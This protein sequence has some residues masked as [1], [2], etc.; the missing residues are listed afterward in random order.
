M[1]IQSISPDAVVCEILFNEMAP[2]DDYQWSTRFIRRVF[3]LIAQPIFAENYRRD[4][5]IYGFTVVWISIAISFVITAR[6]TEHYDSSVRFTT[7]SFS[8]GVAQVL[9]L[10]INDFKFSLL[11]YYT[12]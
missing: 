10:F 11:N 7:T 9:R 12:I 5:K 6:D 4:F 1:V 8:F 2:I 3:N